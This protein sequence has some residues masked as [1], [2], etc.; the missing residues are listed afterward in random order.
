MKKIV[1]F[2]SN[3]LLG[4]SLVNRFKTDYQV[5]TASLGR[6]DLNNIEGVPYHQ[7]DMVNRVQINEFLIA[8]SPDIII[9]AAAYTN[10]DGS[11]KDKELCWN[12]N[13]RA[14][15]NIIDIATTFN[16]I[17]VHISSDYVFDGQQGSYTE[18]DSVNPLGNYARSKMAAE[19]IIA[20]SNLEYI[21]ARTQ[22]L[23]GFG[24]KVKL[25]FATWVIS[26]LS[27]KQNI[28][29]VT[30]QIGNP[31]YIDDLSESIFRLLE[32]KEFGLFHIAGSQIINR[33]N[34]AKKIAGRF[35]LDESL[36][37]K[38]VTADLKQLAPRP[39][40]S[41]FNIDKLT[42]R[43]DWQPSDVETGLKKLKLKL[44]KNNG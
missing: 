36:I 28:K 44:S 1:I 22:V 40:D 17:L 39:M 23:Y 2:G 11:E 31:T 4:Q 10:V 18:Q 37:E 26:R 20:A 3:G 19:N 34:F 24:N 33:Y 43:I 15:E 41:S 42:N 6:T 25:N 32:R 7:I 13:V 5:V 30:D 35:D 27:K 9:N 38:I 8:E 29:V 21:I 16:P 14:V 12:T